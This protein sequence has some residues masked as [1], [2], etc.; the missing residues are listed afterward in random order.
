MRSICYL[1]AATCDYAALMADVMSNLGSLHAQETKFAMTL[2][3]GKTQKWEYL[4]RKA[5]ATLHAALGGEVHHTY[6]SRPLPEGVQASKGG[7][8]ME[9]ALEA[10]LL[11]TSSACAR[12]GGLPEDEAVVTA[13]NPG[14]SMAD[15]FGGGCI[16]FNTPGGVD[17]W[18]SAQ[19]FDVVFNRDSEFLSLQ[20]AAAIAAHDEDQGY[21]LVEEWAKARP[22]REV[23]AASRK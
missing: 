10:A 19:G 12:Q 20:I 21:A 9:A 17:V 15:L 14:S 23:D 11:I 3:G 6:L 5:W 8:N 22:V 16:R 18:V 1:V 4:D 7:A 2:D 13:F